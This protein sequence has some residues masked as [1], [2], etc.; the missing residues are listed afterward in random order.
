MFQ[1]L[2]SRARF[3]L[4]LAL[5]ALLVVVVAVVA[6][7]IA[8]SNLDPLESGA[9]AGLARIG[10]A[11]ALVIVTAQPDSVTSPTREL[12]I[13]WGLVAPLLAMIP[14]GGAAWYLSGRVQQKVDRAAADAINAEEERNSR[15]QEVIHEL[16]TPLAVMGTNLEL[17]GYGADGVEGYIEAARRAAD[18]MARTV[19]D[20]AGHGGLS[21]ETSAGPFSLADIA[22]MAVAEH[23]GPGKARGLRVIMKGT[24]ETMVPNTD[25]AALRTAIGN[26][27][28]NAVRLAPRGSMVSVDWGE[29]AG[30]A[31]IAVS[32][33]GPGLAEQLHA[34]VFERGWQGPHDR[35]R[36]S[37]SGLGLTIA[38]QL[39]EAQGGLVSLDSDEGGGTDLAIWLP[40]EVGA[41][42]SDVIAA[43]RIHPV[44]RPWFAGAPTT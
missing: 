44:L 23:A 13:N 21:V 4:V 39:T 37:E 30:W 16:R 26:F 43:D 10:D 7:L 42:Q 3:A 14:A 5:P 34:R 28:S 6:T 29:Y 25:P 24:T 12:V 40:L 8:L 1:R 17:A 15:L 9:Q 11:I 22:G 36:G 33:E 20:L 31:W 2:I 18:R 32:D 27:L 38:R 35:D 19:D 41:N